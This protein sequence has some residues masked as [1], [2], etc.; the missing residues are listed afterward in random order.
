MLQCLVQDMVRQLCFAWRLPC[1]CSDRLFWATYT[2]ASLAGFHLLYFTLSFL[3]D[4]FGF[5]TVKRDVFSFSFASPLSALHTHSRVLRHGSQDIWTSLRHVL[6][7]IW[8]AAKPTSTVDGHRGS[9]QRFHSLQL[10]ANSA[11]RTCS[12]RQHSCLRTRRAQRTANGSGCSSWHEECRTDTVGWLTAC[13]AW[14]AG[15]VGA[16]VGWRRKPRKP[17]SWRT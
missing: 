14:L 13:V 17:P 15:I 12:L 7:E 6:A 8:L 9:R 5:S 4:R 3:V 10:V 2:V 1:P 11:P 16:P